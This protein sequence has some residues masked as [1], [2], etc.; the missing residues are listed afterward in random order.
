MPPR[1]CSS[2]CVCLHGLLKFIQGQGESGFAFFS[3]EL[4]SY[5]SIGLIIKNEDL[6][7]SDEQK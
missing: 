3:I 7:L 1:F 6:F 4:I 2:V 5:M